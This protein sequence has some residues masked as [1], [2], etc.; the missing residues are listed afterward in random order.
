VKLRTLVSLLLF[1][2]GLAP[3]LAVIIINVPLVYDRL[4]LFYHK[5]YLQNLRADFL[6]LDQH[7]AR[8]H[9]MVLLLAKL[10]EPG[11]LPESGDTDAAD[12]LDESRVRYTDWVNRVLFDQVDIV[13]IVFL[14][15]N[16]QARF[17]LDRDPKSGVLKPGDELPDL[18]GQDF[19]DAG[20]KLPP[21]TVVTGP[22]EFDAQALE[23]NPN[24]F[25]TLSFIAPVVTASLPSGGAPARLGSVLVKMDVGGLASAYRGIYWVHDSGRYLEYSTDDTS[26]STAFEDFP[27]LQDLFA[28]G[29]LN[30]WEYKDQQIFWLPLFPTETSGP[31][32]VGRSVDASPITE[33]RR[34]LE[35]RVISIVGVLLLLVFVIAWLIAT[36]VDRFS[37][38]LTD[39]ISRV[40]EQD[41]PVEFRWK[42][43]QELKALGSNLTRLAQTHAKSNEALRLHARELEE[44]NRYKSEFLA[45]VSHEL[46][47]PLNSILLLSRMLADHASSG[48]SSEQARQARVIHDAGTDL[49]ALI[50]NI[51]DLSRI[52]AGEVSLQPEE[53]DLRIILSD[54]A[55]LMRPQFDDKGIR[56]IVDMDDRVPAIVLTDGEKV[57]QILV[58]FLSNAVKFT[59]QGEVKLELS[60][61]EDNDAEPCPVRISVRDSGIGIPQDKQ[62]TV[63]EAFKQADGSTS[64][65]YGGTGL[66]LTISR[67]LAALVGGKIEVQSEVNVGSVF[68]LLLPL[69]MTDRSQDFETGKPNGTQGASRTEVSVPQASYAGCRVLLVDDDVRNLL[70][71]TPL[72][73]GWDIE[74]T[75]AGDGEEALETLA[76][77]PG[78]DLVLMDLMMPGID[79]YE[80]IRRMRSSSDL[81]D[82][83]VV[84]L[85][86]RTEVG[87][88]ERCIEF[89]ANAYLAKPVEP[90]DLKQFL[91]RYLLKADT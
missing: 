86:A 35:I 6:D 37:R 17:W 79:G 51:L 54:I 15:S 70:A 23:S 84:A 75:A 65:R 66:G 42:G 49:R 12:A 41:E 53:V 32:W 36:R 24:Q 50:D 9:E 62:D 74:V 72:L 61:N 22:I 90:E 68:S 16:K 8:R 81:K 26:Q 87:E 1:L 59:E 55:D 3:L 2:F 58:N 19:L 28:R 31:L 47:T 4:E 85:T 52:E 25:M 78:Y 13:Q 60:V 38:T 29:E 5:S 46:R 77:D 43:P 7:I 40:L 34:V 73:E 89:G 11:M 30:L 14:D 67:E 82:I 39:G 27:G 45:N 88:Q 21:G 80:T 44:S 64:R 18:P 69:D 33:F 56:L 76:T 57:R 91:D 83:S 71:L 20:K 48:L 10:P 63:F